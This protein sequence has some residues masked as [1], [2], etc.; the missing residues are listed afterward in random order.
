MSRHTADGREFR[1]AD[2]RQKQS[3]VKAEE[4]KEEAGMEPEISKKKMKLVRLRDALWSFAKLAGGV[5]VYLGALALVVGLLTAQ[6]GGGA[7]GLTTGLVLSVYA[8]AVIHTVIGLLFI[9]QN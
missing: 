8:T 9:N 7:V 2:T 3:T 4:A 5:A 1:E 6:V